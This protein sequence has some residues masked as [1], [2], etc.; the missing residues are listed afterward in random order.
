MKGNKT[1]TRGRKALPPEQ[2]KTARLFIHLTPDEKVRAF[3][4]AEQAGWRFSE[5]ARAILVEGDLHAIHALIK[6]TL[7]E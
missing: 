2:R 6:V 1:E 7:G 5:F 3:Q 4:N